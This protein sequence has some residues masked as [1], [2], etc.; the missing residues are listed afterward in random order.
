[1]AL[2]MIRFKNRYVISD[3][4]FWKNK[5]TKHVCCS[6]IKFRYFLSLFS[7]GGAPFIIIFFFYRILNLHRFLIQIIKW[8]VYNPLKLHIIK[9]KKTKLANQY[10]VSLFG[11]LNFQIL[12]EILRNLLKL[13]KQNNELTKQSSVPLLEGWT[14]H[15]LKSDLEL[16]F[17][18]KTL[19]STETELLDLIYRTSPVRR[20]LVYRRLYTW[21]YCLLRVLG[22]FMEPS[23]SYFIWSLSFFYFILCSLPFWFWFSMWPNFFTP[24][25]YLV[26]LFYSIILCDLPLSFCH[27]MWPNSLIQLLYVTWVLINYTMSLTNSNV[28][29]FINIVFIDI[30][31]R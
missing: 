22:Y 4:L 12:K 23:F 17:T 15:A 27:S 26:Y 25:F 21:V 14:F 5:Q 28:S 10:R 3:I 9:K 24:L 18:Q 2:A 31:P 7:K 11:E 16:I 8:I 19:L 20:T 6:R 1:M 13:Y 29:Y 30:C